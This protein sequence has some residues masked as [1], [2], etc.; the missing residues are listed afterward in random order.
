MA[1]RYLQENYPQEAAAIFSQFQK[2]QDPDL[3]EGLA[4]YIQSKDP[5]KAG[6]LRIDAML[7]PLHRGG[8]GDTLVE[9]LIRLSCC[10]EH[11]E[12]LKE[13]SKTWDRDRG[14]LADIANIIEK[15]LR[16]EGKW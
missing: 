8:S 15:R 10:K 9:Q 11:V 5:I 3:L 4:W 12:R 2:D 14:L 13:A 6:H 1:F 16:E 7:D